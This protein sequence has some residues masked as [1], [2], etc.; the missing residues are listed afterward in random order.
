MVFHCK[1]V[2]VQCKGLQRDSRNLSFICGQ[3]LEPMPDAMKALTAVLQF[4]VLHSLQTWQCPHFL[5]SV[6]HTISLHLYL[7][8][9]ESKHD[10]IF[11]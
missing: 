11:L 10:G 5:L 6:S 2:N 3:R 9:F 8:K 4:A 1:V 7:S